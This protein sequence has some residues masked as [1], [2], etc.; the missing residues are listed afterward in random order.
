ME[1]QAEQIK[2]KEQG[3]QERQQRT[4]SELNQEISDL[5]GVYKQC[6]KENARE[7]IKM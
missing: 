6:Q 5:N 4:E 3:L 2:Q 7:S 1:V